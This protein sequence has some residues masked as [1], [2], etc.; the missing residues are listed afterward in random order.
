VTLLAISGPVH[1]SDDV[2]NTAV[3]MLLPFAT[4]NMTLRFTNVRRSLVLG[5]SLVQL[6]IGFVACAVMTATFVMQRSA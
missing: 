3:W 2:R 5:V 6:W 4:A 1:V